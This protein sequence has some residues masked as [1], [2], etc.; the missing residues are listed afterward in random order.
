MASRKYHEIV[1]DLRTTGHT[2]SVPEDTCE[3]LKEFLS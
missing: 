2:K 1:T 3:I